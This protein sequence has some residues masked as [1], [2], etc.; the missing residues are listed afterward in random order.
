MQATL[1]VR[2]ATGRKNGHL[3]H[4][5]QFP[6]PVDIAVGDEDAEA[7]SFGSCSSQH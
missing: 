6:V 5:W 1:T 3:L 2:K 7:Y 4:T